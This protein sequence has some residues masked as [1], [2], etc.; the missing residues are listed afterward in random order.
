MLYIRREQMT[1]FKREAERR[2][3]EKLAKVIPPSYPGVSTALGPEGIMDWIETG[4][5][6][7]KKYGFKEY[8]DI[9]RYV[10]LMFQLVNEKFDEDP[11]LQW[12]AAILGWKNVEDGLRLAAL[13]RRAREESAKG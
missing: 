4:F 2:Y 5:D 3:M 8:N 10:H 9:T 6:K 7:A 12:A 13:E 11:K 1:V